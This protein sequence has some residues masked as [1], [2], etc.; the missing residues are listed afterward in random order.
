MYYLIINKADLVTTDTEGNA[1]DLTPETARHNVLGDQIIID[2][3]AFSEL[4]VKSIPCE[5]VDWETGLSLMET[6]EWK[7]NE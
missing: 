2:D 3:T 5:L 1:I 6:P 7:V 4:G